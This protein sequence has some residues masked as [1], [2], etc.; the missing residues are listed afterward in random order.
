MRAARSFVAM[1]TLLVLTACATPTVQ[2]P[3]TPPAG[4][5]GA[6]IED[7][8][9]ISDDGARLPYLRWVPATGEPWAVIVALHGMNDHKA[10]F[11]L[12]GPAWAERGIAT[13]SYD[14]RGFGQAPGHGIWGG[15]DR[16]VE[17]L[18]TVTAL[19]KARHPD[20]IIAVVG[21]SMGGSVATAAFA[22]DRP[23]VADQVVLLAPGVWGWDAQGP[24]NSVSLW[25]TARALGGLSVEAPEF[26]ARRIHASDNRLE[27]I[28]SGRDPEF[29]RATR[30]DTIYGLVDLMQTASEQLGQVQRPTLLIYGAHDEIVEKGPMRRALIRA[31]D[32]PNLRTAWYADG[33]HLLNRDLGAQKTYDDVE[34]FLRDPDAPL[35]SGALEVLTAMEADQRSA[36]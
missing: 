22:S 6:R 17:D 25:V 26:I 3:L 5:A 28:R 13:Y 19:V 4:F 9:F 7:R 14:Q 8:A 10:A 33:W 2:S 35:P 34:G 15:E 16:M 12:A 30:F 36:R 11:R 18:R 1:L 21:E 31:G 32:A 20:A 24:I 23:P 27:L 29:I